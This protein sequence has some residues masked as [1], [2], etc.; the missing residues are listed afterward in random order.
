MIMVFFGIFVA[1][2]MLT[3]FMFFLFSPV[4]LKLTVA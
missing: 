2:L 3:R 1:S 4:D